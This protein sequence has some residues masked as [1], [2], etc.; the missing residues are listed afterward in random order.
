MNKYYGL[1]LLATV[2]LA[3]QS[4]APVERTS[5]SDSAEDVTAIR[6]HS[7]AFDRAISA[8]D[9]QSSAALLTDDVI[10]MV[11]NQPA[12]RG[13]EAVQNRFH[14]LFTGS[15]LELRSTVD[16]V[17]IA[18]DW[19]FVRGT[20]HLLLTPRDGGAPTDETGKLIN[21]L[22]REQ[23]GTWRLARHIWNADHPDR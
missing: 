18:G 7:E 15:S 20:Y 3:C 16:E 11:P 8:G 22:G 23:N 5:T 14:G 9:E 4:C 6:T 21:I 13:R 10:W 1:P 2:L 12:L 19:G 17:R